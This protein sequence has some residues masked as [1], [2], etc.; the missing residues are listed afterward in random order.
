MAMLNTVDQ[1]KGCIWQDYK[2]NTIINTQENIGSLGLV[3]RPNHRHIKMALKFCCKCPVEFLLILYQLIDPNRSKYTLNDR[4]L[5][6][7]VVHLT[8]RQTLREMHIRI[9]SPPAREK[10]R[11]K[12][13]RKEKPLKYESPY[14]VP[15]SFEPVPRKYTGIYV[16]KHVQYPE[17]PYFDYRNELVNII[18]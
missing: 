10:V 9:P 3:L 15:Y 5:L 6:S 1:L 2:D 14:L 4:L 7:A 16:N 18:V 8:M 12:P 11:A 13:P 17:S